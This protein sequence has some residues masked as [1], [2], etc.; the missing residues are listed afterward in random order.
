MQRMIQNDGGSGDYREVALPMLGIWETILKVRAH[1]V[2]YIY[3]S[4]S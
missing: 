2:R 1:N 3:R 4:S